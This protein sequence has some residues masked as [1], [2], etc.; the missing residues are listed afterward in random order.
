MQMENT[1]DHD[2]FQSDLAF[3]QMDV[4][5]PSN[6]MLWGLTFLLHEI[7]G[8]PP[9][10]TPKEHRRKSDMEQSMPLIKEIFTY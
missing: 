6:R 1:K 3:R 8:D 10:P 7:R 9:S 5:D 2:I 4:T